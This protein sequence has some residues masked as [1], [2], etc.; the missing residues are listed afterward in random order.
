MHDVENFFKT[1]YNIY[2]HFKRR[3][4]LLSLLLLLSIIFL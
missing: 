3:E 1:F 2:L 4:L